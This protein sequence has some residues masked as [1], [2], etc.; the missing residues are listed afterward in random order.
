MINILNEDGTEFSSDFP[1][2]PLQEE[3]NKI[4]PQT[5]ISQYSQVC[6]IYS[7]MWCDRCP[8]GDYWKVPEENK[9]IWDKYQR[10]I[11]EYDKVHNPSIVRNGDEK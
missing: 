2:N 3:W 5:P 10:Q 11:Y 4:Y 8:K 7:C 9:E 6:D 1:Q